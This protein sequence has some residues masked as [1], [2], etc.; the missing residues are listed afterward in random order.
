MPPTVPS[1]SI[2]SKAQPPEPIEINIAFIGGY[3]PYAGEVFREW[4]G[5][6]ATLSIADTEDTFAAA[7]RGEGGINVIYF[8]CDSESVQEFVREYADRRSPKVMLAVERSEFAFIPGGFAKLHDL[9]SC[10]IG[11]LTNGR[12][13]SNLPKT[14]EDA[15]RSRQSQRDR[16]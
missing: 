1:K 4:K 14:I 7:F 2:A 11:I 5:G 8:N 3:P 12:S 6:K 10:D 13:I 16:E 9:V 15:I